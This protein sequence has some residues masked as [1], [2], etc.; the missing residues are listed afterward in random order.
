MQTTKLSASA[1]AQNS[2]N[3]GSSR[4]CSPTFGGIS[5]PRMPSFAARS[6]SLA[7]SAGACSGAEASGRKCAGS[8]APMAASASLFTCAIARPYSGA[9][10]GYM[11]NGTQETAWTST[12]SAAISASR[13]S[14]RVILSLIGRVADS[15]IRKKR[16]PSRSIM[17]VAK[18]SPSRSRKA[19]TSGAIMWLC[20]STAG[21]GEPPGTR[22]Q[23]PRPGD[24]R[25]SPSRPT[26]RASGAEHGE[27]LVGVEDPALHEL[28][29]VRL[30]PQ[31]LHRAC[32]HRPVQHLLLARFYE[33]G[34]R[35][36]P[37]NVV[38]AAAQRLEQAAV[39]RRVGIHLVVLIHQEGVR[40]TRRRDQR[41]LPRTL[42][43]GAGYGGAHLHAARR[44]GCGRVE[45]ALA[46]RVGERP[47]AAT[48]AD[49]FAAI[50]VHLDR[51]HGV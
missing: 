51:Q 31:R 50:A 27:N 40:P 2:S 19:T 49:H 9:T 20:R 35:C 7:A 10:S 13:T 14:G 39:G 21:T 33:T 34:E 3:C 5:T 11:M 22:L 41:R 32:Q 46:C 17:R 26:R 37:P 1:A 16:S 8:R 42:A 48:L 38:A 25:T 18:C 44:A 30:A 47:P 45:V 28:T 6:S 4:P 12:P 24:A 36:L 29:D 15:W 23:A 43:Q